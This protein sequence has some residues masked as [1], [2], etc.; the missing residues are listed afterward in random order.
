VQRL[1]PS[2][3]GLHH[4][5]LRDVVLPRRQRRTTALRRRRRLLSIRRAR[6]S[7]RGQHCRCWRRPR[8][9]HRPRPSRN[10]LGKW[11]PW[12]LPRARHH[13]HTRRGRLGRLPRARRR[14]HTPRGRLGR[15]P[16]ARRRL[17]TPRGR[18]G[19]RPRACLR[20]KRPLRRRARRLR[21]RRPTPGRDHATA[22]RVRTA[23]AARALLPPRRRHRRTRHCLIARLQMAAH[24]ATRTTG[25]RHRAIRH[26]GHRALSG[27]RCNTVSHATMNYDISCHSALSQ[28][29]VVDT[30]CDERQLRGPQP[31]GACA[32]VNNS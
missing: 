13:L 6:H 27:Q 12:R 25:A 28:E 15:L 9:R 20:Q 22:R 30:A 8:R 7:C 17:H 18:L 32:G 14:L 3:L 26:V 24:R 11:R 21:R 29:H 23:R 1:S 10:H 19:R 31:R 16:R 2:H 4:R 5:L